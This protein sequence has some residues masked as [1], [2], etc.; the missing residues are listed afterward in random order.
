M[1]NRVITEAIEMVKILTGPEYDGQYL[2]KILKEKLRDTHLH[3]TL[4]NVVIPTY[5][6]KL[7]QT[8]IFSSYKVSLYH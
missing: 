8:T 5:D 3:Q 1:C 2:H 6:I 4:T 7:R